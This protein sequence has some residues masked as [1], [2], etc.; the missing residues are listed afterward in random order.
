MGRLCSGAIGHGGSLAVDEDD[1][2]AMVL[3]FAW[4]KVRD[5]WRHFFT[6]NMV[7]TH[8]PY[9]SLHVSHYVA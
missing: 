1:R 3:L 9:H 6:N 2:D 7:P 5:G 4:V 8:H